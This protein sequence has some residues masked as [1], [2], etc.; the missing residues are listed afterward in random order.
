VEERRYEGGNGE[1]HLSVR[2][3][4]VASGTGGAVS[5]TLFFRAD[6]G[7]DGVELWKSDGT[8]AEMVKD[9]NP[10]SGSSYPSELTAVNDTLSS[11]LPTRITGANCGR[12][13]AP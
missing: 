2:Q 8:K 11:A 13:T 5:G 9:I 3:L 12:V 1:R 7:T 6:D 4:F 10:G